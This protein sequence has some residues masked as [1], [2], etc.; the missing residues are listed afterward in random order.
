LSFS[1]NEIAEVLE[2]SV[3]AVNSALQRARATIAQRLPS[4]SQQVELQRLGDKN[5]QK[6]ARQY[7]DAIDQRDI[8][9]LMSMLTADATWSMPPHPAYYEGRLAVEEFHRRDVTSVKWRHRITSAN[10]QLAVGCYIYDE[11]RAVY[12]ATVLDVLNLCNG[13]VAAVT[14]FF[15]DQAFRGEDEPDD[16]VAAVDF[17]RFGLP[18]E[19]AG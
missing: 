3:A 6:L 5:V 14:A 2:M 8:E 16:Y 19:L 7:A 12:V 4:D 15:T 1:A 9:T 13:L 18:D 17:G 11:Q 10:G